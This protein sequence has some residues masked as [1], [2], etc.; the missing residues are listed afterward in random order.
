MCGERQRAEQRYYRAIAHIET[1]GIGAESR[2]DQ[3]AA[4]GCKATPA[5]GAAALCD[6][7]KRMQMASDLAVAWIGGRFVSQRQRAQHDDFSEAA[8]DI[9]CRVGVMI[10]GKPD[11][12]AA[13]LQCHQR[14]ATW[15]RQARRPAAVMKTVAQ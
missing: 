1:A 13:A 14:A 8:A 5:H 4:V 9:P 12:V 7:G 11:P 2:H 3:T 15:L 6:T 10:A